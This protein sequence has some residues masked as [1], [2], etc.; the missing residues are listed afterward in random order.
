MFVRYFLAAIAAWL[1]FTEPVTAGNRKVCWPPAPEKFH[2]KRK[3]E[4]LP[5]FPSESNHYRPPDGHV[6][7]FVSSGSSRN[8]TPVEFYLDYISDDES[9]TELS[10]ELSN[11]SSSDTT[12]STF[13][14]RRGHR[15]HYIPNCC[16]WTWECAQ[17]IHR[18]EDNDVSDTSTQELSDKIS[19]C[20][21]QYAH[22]CHNPQSGP[23]FDVKDPAGTDQRAAAIHQS[24]HTE[25]SRNR[26]RGIDSKALRQN[27]KS[28]S[29][30]LTFPGRQ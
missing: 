16:R 29:Q 28:K 7:A 27:T 12:A 2:C 13:H 4:C 14:E 11:G 19:C 1:L 3:A 23:H 24:P 10:P 25:A 15:A 20:V 6:A 30:I 17:L 21:E 18:M 26:Q 5:D 9:F 22:S 8:H